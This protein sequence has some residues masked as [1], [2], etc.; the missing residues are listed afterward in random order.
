M[1]RAFE[2]V[3]VHRDTAYLAG[4]GPVDG[5]TARMHGRVGDD[6]TVDDGSESDRLTAQAFPASLLRTIGDL[7]AITWLRAMVYVIATFGLAGP[8]LTRVGDGFSD[9]VNEAFGARGQHAR[10]TIGTD[11]VGLRC[12]DNHRRD[13]RARLTGASE[14]RS[15][16]NRD[17]CR[18]WEA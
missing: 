9:F 13:D 5:G 2:I 16:G 11:R 18:T 12:P 17:R 14:E 6:L 3:R 1:H 10:G 15:C 4:H 7:D 8:S